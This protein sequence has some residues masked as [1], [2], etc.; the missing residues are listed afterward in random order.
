M[1]K[2]PVRIKTHPK[3]TPSKRQELHQAA[4][5]EDAEINRPRTQLELRRAKQ[6]AIAVRQVNRIAAMLERV[7]KRKRI[8]Y[9]VLAERTGIDRPALNKLLT[10]KHPNP[11][12]ETLYRVANALDQDLTFSLEEKSP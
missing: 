2:K 7:K 3:L 5:E 8:S 12:F 4:A 6:R 10:R 1:R 9:S 11:T